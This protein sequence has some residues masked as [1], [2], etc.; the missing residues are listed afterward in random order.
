MSRVFNG[1]RYT[2]NSE[3]Y[4]TDLECPILEQEAP[5]SEWLIGTADRRLCDWCADHTP[6]P[7]PHRAFGKT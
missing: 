4:H 7:Q 5:S 3:V 1:D 2:K 6:E